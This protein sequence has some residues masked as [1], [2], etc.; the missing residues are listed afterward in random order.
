MNHS[1]PLINQPDLAAASG[2][3]LDEVTSEHLAELGPEDVQ[4]NA[5][6]LRAQAQVARAHGHPQ[7]AENLLRAAELTTVP[8]EE[9]LRMYDRLRPRR[10]SYAELLALA[11]ELEQRYNASLTAA[12]VREAAEVYRARR[13]TREEA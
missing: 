6:T 3:P 10:A 5:T 4:T 1:Y 9:L 2:R 11:Q 12:F 7:L 13:M 8:N